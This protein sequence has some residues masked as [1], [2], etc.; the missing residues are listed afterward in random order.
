MSDPTCPC[1]R[2]PGEHPQEQP[3]FCDQLARN[4]N[5]SIPTCLQASGRSCLYSFEGRQRRFWRFSERL[6]PTAKK[7]AWPY[8]RRTSWCGMTLTDLIFIVLMLA[9]LKWLSNYFINVVGMVSVNAS[10]GELHIITSESSSVAGV[11]SPGQT[12]FSGGTSNYL[13]SLTYSGL[14]N[15]GFSFENIY[16]LHFI[17]GKELMSRM[18]PVVNDVCFDWFIHHL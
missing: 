5:A 6:S 12:I 3:H 4:V 14:E 9:E 7:Y 2:K 1:R 15:L 17:S 16:Y 10:I 13:A 11:M 8:L 18:V